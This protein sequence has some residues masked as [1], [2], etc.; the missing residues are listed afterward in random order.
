MCGLVQ[1]I[2]LGARRK[3]EDEGALG[4]GECSP[5][6]MGGG[7]Q[8]AREMQE[9]QKKVE[10]GA[11][12]EQEWARGMQELQKKVEEGTARE[13]EREREVQ[14]LRAKLAAANGAWQDA[15]VG[16]EQERREWTESARAEAVREREAR[17]ALLGK[18]KELENKIARLGSDMAVLA[19]Q[20]RQGGAEWNGVDALVK[21]LSALD[22]TSSLVRRDLMLYLQDVA[23][24]PDSSPFSSTSQPT[25]TP[26][27]SHSSA[28]ATPNTG[29]AALG[30]PA[31]GAEGN[32]VE[33]PPTA[34]VKTCLL[35]LV[36]HLQQ[37]E[38]ACKISEQAL[39]GPPPPPPPPLA[40]C[41]QP[42]LPLRLRF[43]PVVSRLLSALRCRV[44]RGL[45]WGRHACLDALC[46]RAA[47]V[48]AQRER[49]R[50]F[51]C[52]C[53]RWYLEHADRACALTWP[54][55]CQPNAPDQH[56]Y[57]RGAARAGQHQRR[58]Q[59]G[60]GHSSLRAL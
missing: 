46:A 26:H 11:A 60:R 12:R 15:L 45:A 9:L 16:Q 49:G 43:W 47:H 13:Q 28:R 2:R 57:N 56:N 38:E 7:G 50:E 4:W 23:A 58:A 31:A 1:V 14:E 55:T 48:A 19:E 21:E 30:T 53:A 29:S 35:E 54:E 18:N 22:L 33:A 32:R 41:C 27:S 36:R 3:A 40:S 20:Q 5:V 34:L 8:R 25:P 59:V 10:E 44:A 6:A 24:C 37:A 17:E 51:A 52:L 39:A 42:V